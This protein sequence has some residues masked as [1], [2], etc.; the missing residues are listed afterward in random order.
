MGPIIDPEDRSR[1]EL[2]RLL[3]A[4]RVVPSV[5]DRTWTQLLLAYLQGRPKASFILGD[6]L[7][8]EGL[9]RVRPGDIDQRLR[10]A[11]GLLPPVLA[12]EVACDFVEHVV[13]DVRERHGAFLRG[14][15]VKRGWLRGEVVDAELKAQRGTLRLGVANALRE[16]TAQAMASSPSP[17]VA[18]RASH[19]TATAAA[20]LRASRAEIVNHRDVYTREVRWQAEHLQLRLAAR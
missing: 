14:L 6:Y 17:S 16:A 4:A 3:G 20:T 8:G 10:Y 11:L 7:E 19:L 12:H 2:R 18:Q 5:D 1:R 13:A 15:E 9:P